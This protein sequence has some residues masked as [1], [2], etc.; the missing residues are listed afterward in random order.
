MLAMLTCL[1]SMLGCHRVDRIPAPLARQAAT[2]ALGARPVL[3]TA[4]CTLSR[5]AS[6]ISCVPAAPTR[7]ADDSTRAAR[8]S[9]GTYA[10][11]LASKLVQDSVRHVWSFDAALHNSLGQ[12]IGTL[13]GTS[14]TGSKI[15]VTGIRVTQGTGAVGVINADG[16]APVTAPNQ[17][18]FAY[19]QIVA[20]GANTTAKR[21]ELRVP[22]TVATVSLDILVTTDFPAE[23]SVTFLPPDTVPAWVRADTNIAPPTDSSPGHFAKR[24]VIVAFRPTATLADRQLAIALVNGVVVGGH[25]T[26]D[27]RLGVYYVKV[28]DDAS[29]NGV[30]AA[31][32][33][34]D[35][36]PQVQFAT[37]EVYLDELSSPD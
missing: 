23:Q 34:L 12:S 10:K 29:E 15:F 19:D 2:R 32:Q 6:T 27:G 37:L 4:T 3:L 25:H 18:Y 16:V 11:F 22:N 5:R 8:S 36:L 17:P 30:F 1:L 7:A 33:A 26:A 13:D 9:A 31:M 20:A 14:P 28:P 24:I 21:W 35:A